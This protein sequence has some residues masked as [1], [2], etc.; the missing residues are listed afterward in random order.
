MYIKVC[1][2]LQEKL[3]EYIICAKLYPYKYCVNTCSVATFLLFALLTEGSYPFQGRWGRFSKCLERRN[4]YRRFCFYVQRG[5]AHFWVRP[6]IFP[7][8]KPHSQRQNISAS[9]V[10]RGEGQVGQLP[11]IPKWRGAN[12]CQLGQGAGQSYELLIWVGHGDGGSSTP[13]TA[14]TLGQ[15]REGMCNPDLCIGVRA[16]CHGWLCPGAKLHCYSAD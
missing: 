4:L 2:W 16:G 6:I 12:R 11:W 7:E 8:H 10:A 9:A 3:L 13:A 15:A 1:I 14:S 5:E